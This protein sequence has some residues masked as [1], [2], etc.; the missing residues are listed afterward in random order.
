ML[1]LMPKSNDDDV[2]LAARGRR[3]S[4]SRRAPRSRRSGSFGVTTRTRSRPFMSGACARA[5]EAAPRATSVPMA[6]FCEPWSRRCRV[7]L[8]VSTS[9]MPTMPW[10]A[11][12]A[13]SDSSRAPVR[14]DRAR[15]ADD[16]AGDARR[17]VDRLGV[18]GVDADVADLRRRH[19]DD[20]PVV[21]RVGEDL[22]VA[23][24]RRREDGFA[25]R[26]AARA[27]RAPLED[28]AVGEDEPSAVL[29]RRVGHLMPPDASWTT[30]PSQPSSR[31]CP[32]TACAERTACSGS[33]VRRRA[34][35]IVQRAVG[36]TRTRSARAPSRMRGGG[37]PDDARGAR[38]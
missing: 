24:H 10:R 17:V 2:V 38:A 28:G 33:C 7:S 19:R 15:V 23:G 13:S 20:L 32:S 36:S 12:Y 26:R 25:R 29:L 30:R 8:R 16:E 27:E 3:R 6:A 11:R 21:R 35:S 1:R 9:V 22:L 18:L 37:E 14:G 5:R 34:G 4:P 31:P